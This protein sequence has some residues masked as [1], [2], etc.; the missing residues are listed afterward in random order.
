MDQT[1]IFLP[2][3]TMIALTILV[4]FYMYARRLPFIIRNKLGPEQLTPIA[5]LKLAPPS[6][7]TPADN[8]RNLFEVPVL[9]Y[10]VCLYLFVTNQVDG[11]YVAAAWGFVA[12]RVAHSAIHCTVNIVIIRFWCHALSSFALWFIVVRALLSLTNGAH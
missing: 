10:A 9:F 11:T 8:L 6:V 5:F 2:F 4:W 3:F 1:S 7:L 12:F